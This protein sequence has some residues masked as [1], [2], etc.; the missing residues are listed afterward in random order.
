MGTFADGHPKWLCCMCSSLSHG[1]FLTLSLR[2]QKQVHRAACVSQPR[3]MVSKWRLEGIIGC[4]WRCFADLHRGLLNAGARGAKRGGKKPRAT[5][6]NSSPPASD[7]PFCLRWVQVLIA[8]MLR[9]VEPSGTANF[10]ATLQNPAVTCSQ[11]PLNKL[12]TCHS[13][14]AAVRASR[15]NISVSIWSA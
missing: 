8:P 15:A 2:S 7:A 9:M 6:A 11:R 3:M 12:C 13:P 1:C 14:T 10:A 4:S 5:S